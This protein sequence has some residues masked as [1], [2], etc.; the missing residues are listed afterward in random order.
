MNKKLIISGLILSASLNTAV[1][2]S[3]DL[4][5]SLNKAKES[6]T[7]VA[8]QAGSPL[9]ATGL[10]SM[11]SEGLGLSPETTQAGIGALLNVA[12]QQLSK[13]NFAMISSALPE[14]KQYMGAAPKMDTSAITSML[15]KADEQAKTKAS[16]G[17]IDSAFKQLGIPKETLAP[18]TNMLTG[19]MESNGYGQAAG[20]LK[21]GLSFL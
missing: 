11:A 5:K 14:S 21:Q 7:S 4:T 16:L 9:S 19:Y 3:F 17:Y 18:L 20:L 13:D 6:A 15:G 10:I 2:Q 12:Q 1:A 8:K